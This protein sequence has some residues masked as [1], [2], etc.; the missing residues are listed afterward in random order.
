[1][2]ACVAMAPELLRI[3]LVALLVLGLLMLGV[4][5]L[6]LQ[7]LLLLELLLPLGVNL[8]LDSDVVLGGGTLL[9]GLP[10]DQ[11]G[12]D[13]PRAVDVLA[14]TDIAEHAS[15]SPLP[16]AVELPAH[17]V[18]G[19]ITHVLSAAMMVR[20]G[21]LATAE[22]SHDH[23]L[24]IVVDREVDGRLLHFD[25]LLGASSCAADRRLA[26]GLGTVRAGREIADVRRMVRV[27][28]EVAAA[29]RTLIVKLVMSSTVSLTWV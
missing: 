12:V 8:L 3:N 4:L 19:S 17:V 22:G 21:V 7:L 29:W 5:L 11:R 26:V 6:L 13:C 1:M 14:S 20:V 27:L 28:V 2:V 18:C 24:Y 16:T 15:S 23:V 10:E 9:F 25:L